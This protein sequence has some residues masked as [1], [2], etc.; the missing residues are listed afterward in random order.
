VLLT[1]PG[2]YIGLLGIADMAPS[3]PHGGAAFAEWFGFGFWVWAVFCS[4][5][6][7]CE[8]F[9]KDIFGV[10][11][12][13]AAAVVAY[14]FYLLMTVLGLEA[15]LKHKEAFT[16]VLQPVGWLAALIFAAKLVRRLLLKQKSEPVPP[17]QQGS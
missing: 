5:R 7:L 11:N 13:I 1:L 17:P 12:L 4:I 2:L 10:E 8:R 16:F 6:L 9:L 15:T 3:S 14:G